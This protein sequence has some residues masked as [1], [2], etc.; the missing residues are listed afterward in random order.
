MAS[1]T[2]AFYNV[3][4]NSLPVFSDRLYSLCCRFYNK[5]KKRAMTKCDLENCVLLSHYVGG[6]GN[7][8]T[9][10]RDILSVP[11]SRIKKR[12]KILDP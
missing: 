8:L 10:L 6:S 12:E 2:D 5:I 4:V 1:M 3:I 7:S 11:A 9:T